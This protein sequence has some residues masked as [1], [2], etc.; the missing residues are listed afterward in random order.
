MP[1]LSRVCDKEGYKL[2]N[3]TLFK[4]ALVFV[5]VS[6]I[7]HDP[8][9]YPEPERYNPDRFMPENKHLLVPY[10]YLPFSLG[11]K[12]I[13]LPANL[14]Y[15][16]IFLGPRNCIAMRFAYQEIKLCFANIVRKYKFSTTPETPAE[17]KFKK[18][19]GLLIAEPFQIKVEKR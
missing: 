12:I 13:L 2:G 9:Y 7:H 4:G 6:A 1:Q 10:S 5:G 16:Y 8:E 3:V 18:G 11:I 14:I 15:N 19:A 17:L